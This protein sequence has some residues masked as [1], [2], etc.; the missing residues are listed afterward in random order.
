MYCVN[1]TALCDIL[2][3]QYTAY[4]T[5]RQGV[6]LLRVPKGRFQILLSNWTL[7]NG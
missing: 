7:M 6:K 3:S 5:L 2:Q 1:D 4:I